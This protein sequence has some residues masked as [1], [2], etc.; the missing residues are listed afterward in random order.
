MKYIITTLLML[1]SLS[2]EARDYL[3]VLTEGKV[4]NCIYFCGFNEQKAYGFQ[5]KV[6]G[7]TIVGNR[8]CKRIRVDYPET[9]EY[10]YG[11]YTT[12]AYEENHKVYAFHYSEDSKDSGTLL[13]DFDKKKG[14]VLY[15]ST[16]VFDDDS[17]EVEGIKRKRI[18]LHDESGSNCWIE[19]IGATSE[20]WATLVP[21]PT[22][23]VSQYM[24]SCYENGKCI[25]KNENLPDFVVSGIKHVD[26][27]KN[28][29][30]KNEVYNIMGCKVTNEN[31]HGVF[32]KNG[33]KI[34]K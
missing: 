11:S 10:M 34:I 25:F 21:M 15:E 30:G 32:I 19:G 29:E 23:G 16:C 20:V 33:K 7:D 3:P 9:S 28:D 22:N 12:A 13:M 31:G 24:E 2:I 18:L 17:I 1:A 4:W 26:M 14:D 8:T 27:P 5:I 6:D